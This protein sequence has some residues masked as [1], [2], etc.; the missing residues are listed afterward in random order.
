MSFFGLKVK[1]EKY[2]KRGLKMSIMKKIL[3]FIH[4]IFDCESY[5]FSEIDSHKWESKLETQSHFPD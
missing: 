2:E 5:L 1:I 4:H 3:S